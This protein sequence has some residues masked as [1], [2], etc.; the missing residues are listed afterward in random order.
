MAPAGLALNPLI[1][2]INLSMGTPEALLKPGFPGL[3]SHCIKNRQFSQ[4]IENKYLN[5]P[6]LHQQGGGMNPL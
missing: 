1:L 5:M 4:P 3:G 6:T 2:G